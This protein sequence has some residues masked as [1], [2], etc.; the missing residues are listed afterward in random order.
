MASIHL[1]FLFMLHPTQHSHMF[2]FFEPVHLYIS[3]ASG[4]FNS[5]FE[6]NKQCLY[7]LVSYG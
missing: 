1:L 6:R 3:L 5:A 7:Y 4:Y 2:P